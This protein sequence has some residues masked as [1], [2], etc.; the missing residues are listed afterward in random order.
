[1][2]W[3]KV[4]NIILVILTITNL[5]LLVFVLYREARDQNQ[6]Q[7]ARSDAIL[8]LQKN[9]ITVEDSVVPQSMEL[10]PMQAARDVNGER[11]IAQTLL[12]ENM[13]V[14]ARGGEVYRYESPLGWLQF[15]SDGG[16]QGEFSASAFPVEGQT[17]AEHAEEFLHRL[18]FAGQELEAEEGTGGTLTLCQV[19]KNIPVFNLQ[20]TLEYEGNSLVGITASRRLFGEPVALSASQ[21]VTVA[22]ALAWLLTELNELGDVCSRIDGITPGYVSAASLAGTMTLTPVWRIATDTG[23]YQLDTVSG[24]LSRV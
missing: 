6:Q 8:F 5:V 24:A 1:M 10:L 15:H 23:D 20:A 11:R 3:S 4:K 2:E 7:Q 13:S 16:F 22:T 9:G 14:Q 17:R 21:P 12:G 18:G 19:W